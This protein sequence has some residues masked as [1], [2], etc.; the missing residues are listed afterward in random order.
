MSVPSP[1]RRTPRRRNDAAADEDQKGA[2]ASL[3]RLGGRATATLASINDFVKST[4]SL[5]GAI[6]GLLTVLIAVGVIHVATDH[7]PRVAV[8][9]VI[10]S[11]PSQAVALLHQQPLEA[12]VQCLAPDHSQP[13]SLVYATDPRVGNDVDVR[14]TV[15]VFVAPPC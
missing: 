4:G 8:P 15:M 3:R 6:G 5:I 11:T 1:R 12:S 9:D 7:P 10:M 2:L 14:S 13:P